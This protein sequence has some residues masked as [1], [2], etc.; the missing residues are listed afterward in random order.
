LIT[1][2]P[3]P[4]VMPLPIVIP[5]IIVELAPMKEFWPMVTFPH[6]TVPGTNVCKSSMVHNYGRLK[7]GCYKFNNQFLVM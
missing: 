7:E 3:A 2:E 1:V 6:K 4:T 5:E